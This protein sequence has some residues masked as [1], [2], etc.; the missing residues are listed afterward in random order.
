MNLEYLGHSC[1]KIT[2]NGFSIVVDPYAPGSVPGLTDLTLSA[3]LVLCSHAHS[4]HSYVDAVK[5]VYKECNPCRI[6]QLKCYHD[7]VEGKK[8]GQ[9][10]IHIIDNENIRIAHFG[11]LGHELS[12]T[13]LMELGHIDIALLPVGGHYTIDADTAYK[14]VNTLKPKT[15]IPMHYRTDNSGYEEI[16]TVNEFLEYFKEIETSDYLIDVT[17]KLPQVV[18][19]GQKNCKL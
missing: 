6:T 18:V 11:D 9:N 8:R 4:D 2:S 16:G 10:I 19:M 1:F 5:L 14:I 7:E 17:N 12:E 15:V 13:L 3:N